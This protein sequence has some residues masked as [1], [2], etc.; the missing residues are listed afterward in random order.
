MVNFQNLDTAVNRGAV[1]LLS[2]LIQTQSVKENEPNPDFKVYLKYALRCTTM[3]LRSK[4]ALEV[5]ISTKVGLS[6]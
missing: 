2:K 1:E 3:C 5:F 6:W 4:I